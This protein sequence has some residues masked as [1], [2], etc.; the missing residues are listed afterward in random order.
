M[1]GQLF[2]IGIVTAT[3]AAIEELERA[4]VD[5]LELVARH[6]SGDYGRALEDSGQIN[7]ET[8]REK[9]GTILSV[10]QVA[11]G[12]DIWV[13]TSLQETGEVHTCVLCPSEW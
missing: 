12:I 1:P 8:V 5:P 7:H 4:G 10:Y 2:S 6:A 9:V 11:D 3:P 13:A